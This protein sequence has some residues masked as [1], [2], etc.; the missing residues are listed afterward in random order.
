MRRRLFVSA[1]ILIILHIIWWPV[2]IK[3][4][5]P[6]HI[7]EIPTPQIRNDTPVPPV[8]GQTNPI[9][10]VSPITSLEERQSAFRAAFKTP[11]VFYGRV[12]DQHDNPVAE[13]T[14]IYYISDHPERNSSQYQGIT[15][16][17]GFF[18]ISE[19]TGISLAVQ[20]SKNGYL[21]LPPNNPRVT[22]SGMFD[23]AAGTNRHLPDR[24]SPVIFRLHKVGPAEQLVRVGEKN[25]R[26]ARDGSPLTISV[27]EQGSHQLVLRCW[28]QELQRLASQRQYDWRLEITVPNGGLV[29]RKDAF[30]FEAPEALYMPSDTVEMP[31]SLANQWRSFAERSYFIRFGDG[32]FARVNLRMRA[33]G[34]HFVVWESFYNPKLGSPNLEARADN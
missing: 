15:D 3:S 34:D 2:P 20:V 11:I 14:V 22:S 27:D 4:V 16:G 26:I 33:G 24:N 1:L 28:N 25:F 19:V 17:D 8:V 30:D 21:K 29:T 12:M 31:A 5:E 10:L 23:Y 9:P 18:S 32:T 13:A 6:P 7:V